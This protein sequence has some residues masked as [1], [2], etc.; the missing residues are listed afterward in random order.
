MPAF[1]A[2]VD[3]HGLTALEGY[4]QA[5]EREVGHPVAATADGLLEG[6]LERLARSE[7]DVVVADLDDLTGERRPHNVPGVVSETTWRR[8]LPAPLSDV[9]GDDTVRHRL[10][11][12]AARGES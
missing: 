8:R 10:Q 11:L 7:A 4:R 6:A 5:V 2:A 9:L 3:V 1:A 12:I